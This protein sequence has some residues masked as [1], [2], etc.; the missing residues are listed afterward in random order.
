MGKN[1]NIFTLKIDEARFARKV[2]KREFLKEFS[3]NVKGGYLH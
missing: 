1:Q 2:V 3:N